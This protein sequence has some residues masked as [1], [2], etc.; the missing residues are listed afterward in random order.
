MVAALPRPSSVQSRPVGTIR[1]SRVR[2]I[3]GGGGDDVRVVPAGTTIHDVDTPADRV[4][5]I[6]RGEVRLLQRGPN[7]CTRLVEILGPGDWLGVAAVAGLPTCEKQA[8]AV[9][10]VAVSERPVEAL[11]LWL[12]Q[13]PPA[14]VL[15]VRELAGQLHATRTSAARLFFDDCERRVLKTL[16]DFATTSAATSLGAGVVRLNITHK[17]LAHA[18]GVARETV[19]LALA[20]LKKRS[21]VETGRSQLT[22]LPADLVV[23]LEG[24]PDDGGPPCVEE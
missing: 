13:N 7:G 22:F 3:A 2:V 21:L 24:G 1:P 5:L 19:T 20:K 8:V 15:F 9:T 12:E 11:L 14:A 16:V 17:S 23:A 18:I 10:D 4:Y 6:V